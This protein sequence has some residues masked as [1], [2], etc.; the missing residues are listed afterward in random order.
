MINCVYLVVGFQFGVIGLA[1]AQVLINISGA[2]INVWATRK[3]LPYSCF[4]QLK[5][6]FIYIL[7]A[8]GIGGCSLIFSFDNHLLNMIS[9]WIFIIISYS[10]ALAVLK[11]EIF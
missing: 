8:F 2:L 7:L 6:I 9:M 1:V 5:D 4:M 10:L 3:L 11:D